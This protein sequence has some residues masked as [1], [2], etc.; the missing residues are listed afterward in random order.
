MT[1][2]VCGNCSFADT[3]YLANTCGPNFVTFMTAVEVLL[4]ARCDFNEA[5]SRL[6]QENLSTMEDEYD[7]IVVGAGVAGPVVAGRLSEPRPGGA[8]PWSVLLLEA[9]PEEPTISSVPAFCFAARGT[10]LDWNFYSD[11]ENACFSTN[12]KCWWPRGKMVGGTGAMTG[13]MYTR[14]SSNIYDEW[15]KAGNTGWSYEDV[16]PYFKKSENFADPSIGDEGYHGFDGPMIVRR[17]PH[18]PKFADDLVKAGAEMGFNSGDFSGKNLTNFGVAP[19]MADAHALRAS[20]PRAFLRPHVADRPNLRL[21]TGVQVS[22]VLID[23]SLGRATGVGYIRNGKEY[24]VRVRKEVILS[25]GTIGTAQILMHSGIGPKEELE[26]IGQQVIFDV[27]GVGKN[28]H[29]H[30]SAGVPFTIDDDDYQTLTND[31]I[32]EFLE[33]R[34]GP[35]AS[36]AITQVTAFLESIHSK[37]GVPDIQVFFDGFDANCSATGDAKECVNGQPGPCPGHRRRIVARP[38]LVYPYSRGHL[39]IKDTNPLTPPFMSAGY[40]SDDRDMPALIN[41]MMQIAERLPATTAMK[42]WGMELDKTPSPGCE[43]KEFGTY[44]YWECTARRD[45]GPENHQSGTAKMGADDDK[46]AVVDSQL[47]VRVLPNLRVADASIF[48]Q[49]P[50]GNPIPAVI[51]VAERCADF[52]KQAYPN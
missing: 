8:K 48:P 29:N 21:E 40:F 30:V 17:F 9:G 5:C 33:S 4:T 14:G 37:Q 43:D 28:L 23:E 3:S 16:L 32:K 44:E 36:T 7:F 26:Y 46:D 45:T 12:N 13:M 1:V 49:V 11:E 27:P 6:G 2:S 34:K 50:N 51:M 19:V 25:A 22:R 10:S 31:S 42:N 41:G 39:M 15:A 52:I 47:R 35:M 24:M 38:T 20:T 18:R